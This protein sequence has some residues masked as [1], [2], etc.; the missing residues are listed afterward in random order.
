LLC[1]ADWEKITFSFTLAFFLASN[2]PTNFQVI[3]F[4]VLSENQVELPAGF[5]NPDQIR[6]IPDPVHYDSLKV[7]G[8]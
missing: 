2:Y 4:G 1:N 3:A 7:Q 5:T 8:K 6:V